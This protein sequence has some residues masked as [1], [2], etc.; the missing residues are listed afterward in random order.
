MLIV[1][2]FGGK[3]RIKKVELIDFPENAKKILIKILEDNTDLFC[4]TT[5]KTKKQLENYIRKVNV[6]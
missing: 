1:L 2:Q 4:C 3:M 5:L 6:R